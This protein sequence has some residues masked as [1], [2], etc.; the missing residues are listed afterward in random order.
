MD[1]YIAEEAGFCFGVKRA[2]ILINQL[3][4]Q[5]QNV[6]IYG[7]LI[8]NIT[9]LKNLEKKGIHCIKKLDEASPGKKIVIRTHGIP[10]QEE[11]ALKK[12]KID[13]L[14]ATCPLVKKIHDI[15]QKNQ[16]DLTRIVIVGDKNHPEII[17]ARSYAKNAMVINSITQAEKIKP[18]KE[19]IVIAQTTLD[20][21]FF[22][23][24]VF[25]LVDKA[26]KLKIHNTICEATRV[27][28]RA[29]Q[30]L[31]PTV[32][33]VV[34]IGGKNSS[35]TKKLYDISHQKNKN[36]FYFE[37]SEDLYNRKFIN[38]ISKYNSVGITAG[39]STPPDEIEKVK[40]FFQNFKEIK[41]GKLK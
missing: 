22:K 17:A 19:I 7:D 11:E 35:N 2:L 20:S 37:K 33:F 23:K 24:I 29:I 6:Q 12:A 40:N 15:I 30:K 21:E 14:D 34:V 9:V 16:K 13:Y 41:N 36:T 5:K 26:E 18:S 27:R 28:Q 4:R 8:H 3:H 39:A 32:D 31:A 10:L 38:Q 1:I 25:T